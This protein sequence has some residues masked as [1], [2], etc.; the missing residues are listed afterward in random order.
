MLLFI[1]IGPKR[2]IPYNL[3]INFKLYCSILPNFGLVRYVYQRMPMG[4]ST[5]QDMWMSYMIAIL[6]SIPD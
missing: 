1:S 3:I 4:L 5:S 6:N 2:C